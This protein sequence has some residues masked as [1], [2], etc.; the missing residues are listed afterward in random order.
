VDVG[1]WLA[2]IL[3]GVVFV[4]LF[5]V[6]KRRKP[7]KPAGQATYGGPIRFTDPSGR[8]M[9]IVPKDDGTFETMEE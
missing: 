4:A 2:A 8:N 6:I 1:F 5:L 3:A 9:K 7:P